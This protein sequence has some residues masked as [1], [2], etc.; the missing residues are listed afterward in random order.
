MKNQIKFILLIGFITL[1]LSSCSR[2]V[3]PDSEVELGKDY[4]NF[5]IGH[6]V[7]YA[8]DS[9][10]YNDFA[11][12]TDTFRMQY[13]DVVSST[14]FDNEGRPSYIINR[15]KRKTSQNEWGAFLTYYATLTNYQLEVVENNLRFVKLVFPVI[16]NTRWFGN[17][18]IPTASNPELQWFNGWNYRYQQ[19]S[20][21]YSDYLYF[22]NTVTIT[23]ADSKEGNENDPNAFSAQTFSKEIYAKNVGMVYKELTRWEYQPS[24][25]KYRKGFTL[26]LKAINHN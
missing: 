9:I 26:I 1:S 5:N 4:V 2:K 23:Q 20:K 10:I 16:E 22:T 3:I 18:Q 12:R 24:V 8:V 15:W 13:R 11:Q 14:F 6:F 25:I 17:N 19:V 21:S 7:E